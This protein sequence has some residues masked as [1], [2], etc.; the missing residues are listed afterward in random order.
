MSISKNCKSLAV[1]GV[2]AGSSV[3]VQLV[4]QCVVVRI[5]GRNRT[6][7]G[8][9]HGRAL[10]HRPVVRVSF[11]VGGGVRIIGHLGPH[12]VLRFRIRGLGAALR[13][14]ICNIDPQV[15]AF[16]C[17]YGGIGVVGCT[18]CY[19]GPMEQIANH[20]VGSLG[21]VPRPRFAGDEAVRVGQ[22]SHYRGGN[23]GLQ[24]LQGQL[25]GS[26]AFPTITVR[27][28]SVLLAGRGA[29]A[30]ALISVALTVI[31]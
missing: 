20:G 3:V 9:S 4:G 19:F 14:R 2:I 1:A 8:V 27:A 30:P 24:P 17:R 28:M 18:C 13:I 22:G 16:I 15:L 26:S 21:G 10:R 31:W 23:L 11:E 25:T 12:R 7:H 29:S 6:A 5:S